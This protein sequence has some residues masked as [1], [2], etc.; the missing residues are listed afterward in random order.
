MGLTIHYTLRSNT[1]SS[2]QARELL[3]RLRD[4]A[5]DLPLE[6]V[7]DIIELDGPA[8][9]YQQY[10]REHPNRWLLIQAGQYISDPRHQG[11]SYTVA[12][13]HVIAFST[14]P[15]Q[16][17]EP[18]NC[19]L[20]RYPA[21]IEVDDPIQRSVRR[22]IRT[23]AGG[24]RW[25]SFCKTQFASDPTCGGVPHFLRCHLSVIKLLDHARQLG[26]LGDVM[27]EGGF[28]D[29]RDVPTLA[30]QVGQWNAMIAAAFGELKYQLGSE[31]ASPI[32]TSPNFEH[33][34]AAGQRR[35]ET[36]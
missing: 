9:D 14:W 33:L 32:T 8:C 22:R 21:M 5:L 23:G 16:G 36:P 27:D 1:R 6:Q 13:T 18:A 19:G 12:P 20:C 34:A 3:A 10:D 28:W 25:G 2:K 15:G 35:E 26:I 31:V 7:T 30:R 24:W 17:C 4:R 29:Q 11:Y